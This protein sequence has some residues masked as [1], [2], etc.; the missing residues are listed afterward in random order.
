MSYADLVAAAAR[1]TT[2][3]TMHA[4][5]ASSLFELVSDGLHKV[6]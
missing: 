1:A 2:V 3:G 4:S 5:S 6:D